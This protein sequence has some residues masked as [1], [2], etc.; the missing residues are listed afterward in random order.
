LVLDA[1]SAPHP[2][3][4]RAEPLLFSRRFPAWGFRRRYPAGRLFRD[5]ED[6][7]GVLARRFPNGHAVVFPCAPLQLVEI[8]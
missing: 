4:D 3:D 7:R 8:E 2:P 6:L 5:W 1:G